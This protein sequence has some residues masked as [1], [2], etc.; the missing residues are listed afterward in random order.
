MKPEKKEVRFSRLSV[1]VGEAGVSLPFSTTVP[2]PRKGLAIRPKFKA[3]MDCCDFCVRAC[4]KRSRTACSWA[5]N[6]K[7]ALI[8]R[9]G[10]I[11]MN[12]LLILGDQ[13]LLGVLQQ[14]LEILNA[15]IACNQF[16]LGQSDFLFQ[17][18]I[19]FHK[20]IRMII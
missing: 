9:Y 10:S 2:P 17:G 13:F 5:S 19:L 1:E 6:L 11:K 15:F 8:S 18:C 12:L 20:L 4:S 7:V 3:D 14:C 16:T